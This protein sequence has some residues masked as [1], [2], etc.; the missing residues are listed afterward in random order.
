MM[1]D[2]T[3]PVIVLSRKRFTR[4]IFHTKTGSHNGLNFGRYSFSSKFGQSIAL[5]VWICIYPCVPFMG[6]HNNRD[7]CVNHHD[8]TDMS[9]LILKFSSRRVSLFSKLSEK[10]KKSYSNFKKVT[11]FYSNPNCPCFCAV[12]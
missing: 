6:Q 3:V 1:V 10:H 8:C 9:N 7:I 5:F 4:D 11:I 12:P 2:T